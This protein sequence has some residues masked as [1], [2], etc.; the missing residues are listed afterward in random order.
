MAIID[1][2]IIEAT[3]LEI[4]NL[5]DEMA[6]DSV[7]KLTSRQ[8]DLN[9]F[10]INSL[11]EHPPEAVELGFYIFFVVYRMFETACGKKL[12]KIP[13]DKIMSV[14]D[15]N[16]LLFESLQVSEEG[17][18]DRVINMEDLLQP[19]VTEY[20]FEAML[21]EDED[22]IILSQLEV[23]F[24]YLTLKTVVDVLDSEL[25]KCK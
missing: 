24:I 14:Y 7:D 19:Y 25:A 20:I 6:A 4:G 22:S 17:F 3:L 2:D 12:K 23:G 16:Q 21:E 5:T 9:A 11:E 18:A 1:E 15:E 8:M 13:A 10:V